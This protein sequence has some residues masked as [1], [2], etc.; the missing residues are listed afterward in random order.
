MH[1]PPSFPILGVTLCF[2]L[3]CCAPPAA[4]GGDGPNGASGYGTTGQDAA[5]SSSGASHDGG[6]VSANDAGAPTH[7]AGAPP[8]D[9]RC[10][11]NLGLGS[12]ADGGHVSLRGTTVAADSDFALTCSN[13]NNGEDIVYGFVLTHS[14]TIVATLTMDNENLGGLGIVLLADGTAECRTRSSDERCVSPS[15]SWATSTARLET[16]LARG[17]WGLVVKTLPG[18]SGPFTLVVDVTSLGEDDVPEGWTCAPGYW[19]D[20]ACDCGCGRVDPDCDDATAT[21]CD[22]CAGVGSCSARTCGASNTMI[23]PDN[24]ALC[25]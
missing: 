17:T 21:S 13:S 5:A 12:V 15:Q 22:H 4:P 3:L 8:G 9:G 11:L 7:D 14:S 20:G 24:N 23:Q 25:N 16:T 2:T 1:N 6:A 10:T 18:L 19:S